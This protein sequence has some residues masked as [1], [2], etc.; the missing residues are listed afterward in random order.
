[1]IW[2]WTGPRDSNTGVA[3]IQRQKLSYDSTA[4]L[5]SGNLLQTILLLLQHLPVILTTHHIP[6]PPS[7]VPEQASKLIWKVF[8]TTSL[9][10]VRSRQNHLQL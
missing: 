4:Q 9:N 1:M 7:A 5:T 10:M 3:N 6:L 8:Q 2:N